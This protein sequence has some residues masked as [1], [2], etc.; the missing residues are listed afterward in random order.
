MVPA[1][2]N[3]ASACP[4]EKKS[5]VRMSPQ[6]LCKNIRQ[7]FGNDSAKTFGKNI[8]QNIRQIFGK[9]S[10]NKSMTIQRQYESPENA[11]SHFSKNL[12]KRPGKNSNRIPNRISP[13]TFIQILRKMVFRIFSAF[14]TL[15]IYVRTY[16][17]T[18]VYMLQYVGYL[19]WH[20][21]CNLSRHDVRMVP[22][23]KNWASACPR[24]K[25][26]DVGNVRT[27]TDSA[28]SVA[29]S[30][31]RTRPRASKLQTTVYPLKINR[32]APPL[33][34]NP[35]QTI[36]IILFFDVRKIFRR[37]KIMILDSFFEVF[38]I[39]L[40][41]WTLT[42]VSGVFSTKNYTIYT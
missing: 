35:F 24:E 38:G 25:K 3:W 30:R 6:Q 21:V 4:R 33:R 11:K 10:A 13:G 17:Y 32:T 19:S 20:D 8:R 29:A 15:Y 34:Q 23:K 26:S 18:Y 41:S 1:K 22:A 37:P 39:I 5:D 27:Q 40:R 36:P 12:D 9:Y 28:S 7:T 14:Y 16:I 2:R 42:D 31:P